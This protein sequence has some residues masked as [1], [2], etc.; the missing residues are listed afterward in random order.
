MPEN[1]R[2][3]GVP[4]GYVPRV[5]PSARSPRIAAVP[6]LAAL[7]QYEGLWVAVLEGEV[8]MAEQTSHALALKLHDMDHVKRNNVVVEFVRPTGDSYIVGAG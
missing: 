2:L 1:D 8:V 3:R 7:D 4:A 5:D 6:R